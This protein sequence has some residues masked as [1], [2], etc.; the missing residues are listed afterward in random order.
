MASVPCQQE[1]SREGTEMTKHGAMG[2]NIL[3]PFHYDTINDARRHAREYVKERYPSC[4][5]FKFNQSDIEM[6]TFSNGTVE[7]VGVLGF[8]FTI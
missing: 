3:S 7:P 6:V 4:S 8:T 5:D 1:D 2:V